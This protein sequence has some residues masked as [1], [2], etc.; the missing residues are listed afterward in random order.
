M[1]TKE[2][3]GCL[4]IGYMTNEFSIKTRNYQHE[5]NLI[6]IQLLGND[7]MQMQKMYDKLPQYVRN[8][9][10]K[11][12]CRVGIQGIKQL[13]LFEPSPIQ[14]IIDTG[15]IPRLIEIIQSTFVYQSQIDAASCLTIIASGTA[16]H[17]TVL[18]KYDIIPK[19]IK[20]LQSSCDKVVTRCIWILGKIADNSEQYT[21]LMLSNN[22]L[23][24][25]KSICHT[26][27]NTQP[28]LA[29]LQN[30]TWTLS[31]LCNFQPFSD[32]KYFQLTVQIL[33]VMIT[34]NDPKILQYVCCTCSCLSYICDQHTHNGE[35]E[36]NAIVNSRLLNRL[37]QLSDHLEEKIRHAA[38]RTIGNIVSGSDKHTQKVI[39]CGV[40]KKLKY[41][42]N[43]D[44][45]TIKQEAIWVISNITAGSKEQIQA[46][47]DADLFVTLFHV[48]CNEEYEIA[49]EALWT[50]HN[51]IC[52]GCDEQILIL[53]KQGVIKSLCTFLKHKLDEKILLTALEIIENILICGDR[54]SNDENN[55]F[56][57]YVLETSVVDILQKLQLNPVFS[58]QICFKL[59]SIIKLHLDDL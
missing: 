18:V 24:E 40:L 28:Q 58:H 49:Q 41:L 27:I 23:S 34:S 38:L 1:S 51:A 47:T 54:I 33:L 32:W 29:L 36:I 19:L 8:C 12:F 37:I 17:K 55:G 11:H 2:R 10:N 5:L 43:D 45:H 53:V 4:V 3:L 20:L 39:N 56:R 30:L 48:L 14:Y 46:V 31:T 25:M 26:N 44:V 50:I 7:F 6:I 22:I 15:V 13:L 42:I 21:N 9:Q 35:T 59:T 52:G 16:S 57:E